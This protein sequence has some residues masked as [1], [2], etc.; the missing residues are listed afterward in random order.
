M[1]SAKG[2]LCAARKH[3]DQLY[4]GVNDSVVLN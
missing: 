3:S 4:T 2:Y 1:T